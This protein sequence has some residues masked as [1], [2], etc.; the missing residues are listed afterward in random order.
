ML[1]NMVNIPHTFERY[2]KCHRVTLCVMSHVIEQV[3][4]RE[5]KKERVAS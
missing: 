2:I 3:I 1:D 5:F 4:H